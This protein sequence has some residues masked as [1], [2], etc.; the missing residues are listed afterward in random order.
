[1]RTSHATHHADKILTLPELLA[2]R[3][4][5][6][7][8]GRR[9][10]HC[11]GCFDIVHP[12]HIRHLRQAKA[13]GEVLLV[14][15]TGDAEMR[16]GAGRPLIP[17]ELRA[18]NLAALDFVDWV[19]IECRPTAA[20]LL[21][22]IAPDVYVK[23]REYETNN[24]PR[25]AEERSAV[26]SR[27]GRVVFSS[28][29]VVFSS[30]AL[31]GAL[32]QSVDPSH[33]LLT[34]LLDKPELDA[35]SLMTR[36]A[37]FRAKRVLVVGE[38]ILDTYVL[39][40]RP[41]V[42]GESPIMTLRPLERRQFDGGAAVV[43]LHAAAM[44]ARPVLVT[45]LPESDVADAV[46]RRLEMQGVEVRAI[47]I[48]TPVAEKQRFLVGA[49]KIMKVDLV[50]PILLD[51]RQQEQFV[52]L[53]AAAADDM[54]T[55][56]A[57]LI[58]DFAQGLLSRGVLTRL[59]KQVRR[60]AEV[61]VGDVSGRRGG[62]SAMRSMDLLC[63]SESELRSSMNRFDES[64]PTVTWRLLEESGARAA[65][66]TMGAEGLVVFERR[67]GAAD[68]TD[69]HASRVNGEHVPALCPIGIDPLGCGDALATTAALTLASGGSCVAAG[70]LGAVA[71]A[72][73]VQRIGNLPVSGADLRRGVARIH[74]SM[75]AYAGPDLA[76]ASSIRASQ[77]A[78]ALAST[79]RAS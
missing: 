27:G 14:S 64:L 49:Q 7:G 40:D 52:D 53:A 5:A 8:S 46:A 61:M 6:R 34:R 21:A 58:T 73:Q 25:F 56:H 76:D 70:F 50:E 15:I 47:R 43:A 68:D 74:A 55:C 65:I 32:E 22:E 1:M 44:G 71:A 41:E 28:G 12:G 37:S 63:P 60:R 35:P 39:C 69:P 20:T 18:E 23:G 57:A 54:E 31:I 16:K 62:L 36:I 9:V 19:Y 67:P 72:A 75:L 48:E 79:L 29:D 11:H 45:A 77:E 2:A 13:L 51:A 26:E 30:T 4:H 59:C 17:E 78:S 38:T 33:T 24:D 10:V 42:A 3:T 66:V